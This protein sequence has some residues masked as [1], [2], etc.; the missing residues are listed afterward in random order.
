MQTWEYR[1]IDHG[2]HVALHEVS[3]RNGTIL[4]WSKRPVSF[5][6]SAGGAEGLIDLLSTALEN[7]RKRPV[8]RVEQ[9]D[10][11]VKKPVSSRRL[12]AA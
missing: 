4:N 3:Y 1:I 5:T 9:V 8:L 6:A 10:A 7:A 12:T 11:Q 2:S